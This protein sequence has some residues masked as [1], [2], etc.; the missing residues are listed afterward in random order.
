L[1]EK[2][3]IRAAQSR[4]GLSEQVMLRICAQPIE[5]ADSEAAKKVGRRI[6]PEIG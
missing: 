4:L 5:E 6:R 2:V 3:D 1:G